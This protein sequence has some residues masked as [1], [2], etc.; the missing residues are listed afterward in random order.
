M[1]GGQRFDRRL[2]PCVP[3]HARVGVAGVSANARQSPLQVAEPREPQTRVQ[4]RLRAGL[5]RD[6]QR[7]VQDPVRRRPGARRRPGRRRAARDSTQHD[8][9]ITTDRPKRDDRHPGAAPSVLLDAC[10]VE[11]LNRMDPDA[12]TWSAPPTVHVSQASLE[13]RSTPWSDSS[14]G[15]TQPSKRNCTVPAEI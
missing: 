10:E 5:R 13:A 7:G 8:L 6:L 11:L 1:A 4:E 2:G 3:M 9:E 12:Q 14:P 15:S